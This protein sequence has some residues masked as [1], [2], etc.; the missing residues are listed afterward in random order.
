MSGQSFL[1]LKNNDFLVKLKA[2]KIQLDNPQNPIN[3]LI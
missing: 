3:K 1:L 2:I